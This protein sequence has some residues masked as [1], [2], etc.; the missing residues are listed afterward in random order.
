MKRAGSVSVVPG[1]SDVPRSIPRQQIMR[2]NIQKSIPERTFKGSFD[3]T[4]QDKTI[5]LNVTGIAAGNGW[6]T[7]TA[8]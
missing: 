1:G 8:E 3:V 7:V 2:A 4:Q 5:T 6:V